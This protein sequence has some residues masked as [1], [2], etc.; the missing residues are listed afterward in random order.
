MRLPVRS[1]IL[2]SITSTFR[3]TA[4]SAVAVTAF[5]LVPDRNH[6]RLHH[7]CHQLV[8]ARLVSPAELGA[9]LARIAK[10]RIDFGRPE[11][12]RVHLDQHLA[13]RLVDTFL[14]DAI[15]APHNGPPNMAEGLFDEFAHRMALAGREHIIVG[16]ILLQDQPHP[17]DKIARM[18]PVT[19]GIEVAE[20]Q[21]LLQSTLDRRDRARDLAGDE[22]FASDRTLMVEKNAVRGMHAVG[23][24]VVDRDPVRVEL[25]GRVG[26]AWIERRRLPLRPLLDLAEEFGGRGLI[27]A[28]LAL[29][30]KDANGLE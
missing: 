12:A 15:S 20:E 17:L 18:P 1:K 24:A 6:V 4:P 11:I 5:P 21:L 10:E 23:L 28:G 7:L 2:A 30:A 27:E 9:R 3:S 13:G 22:G 14:L 16:R 8:K 29:A 26:R 19:Q 25:R